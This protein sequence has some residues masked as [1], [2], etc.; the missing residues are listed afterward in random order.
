MRWRS[1]RKS[2][3]TSRPKTCWRWRAWTTRPRS[4]SPA[5]GIRTVD[6]LGE[7]A[8]DEIVE[9][10]IEGMDEERAAALILAARAEEI[11]RLERE[12]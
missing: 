12:G 7:L 1:R 2:T 8:A 9:F 6:D 5:H 3:S 4:R 10:G 11:A